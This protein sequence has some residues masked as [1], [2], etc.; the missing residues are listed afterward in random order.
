MLLYHFCPEHM[1]DSI[2]KEGLTKGKLPVML[3]GGMA[4]FDGCQWLTEEPDQKAQSW[5]T[6]KLLPYSRTAVRLSIWIPKKHLKHLVKAADLVSILPKESKA[7]I[8]EWAGS[9]MWHVFLGRIPAKWITD[10]TVFKEVS[11]VVPP[12][13]E[14]VE[15]EAEVR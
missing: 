12:K 6:Q 10:V 14:Y 4:F 11:V 2:E 8:T 7:I 5:A 13:V 9:E 3:D 15:F 1:L